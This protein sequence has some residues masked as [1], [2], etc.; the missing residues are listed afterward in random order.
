[1]L[2][3]MHV[4]SH[5]LPLGIAPVAVV[6]LPKLLLALP[7]QLLLPLL[8]LSLS[9]PL[10]LLNC[11]KPTTSASNS[12]TAYFNTLSHSLDD[13]TELVVADSGKCSG[14]EETHASPPSRALPPLHASPSS[15]A[16]APLHASPSSRA[17]APLHAS[18]SSRAL[19]PLHASPSSRALPPLHASPSSRALPPLHASPLSRALP[20]LHA[21]PSS[22][23]LLPP[24][25]E[26][27]TATWCT[28]EHVHVHAHGDS[29]AA[30]AS[31]ATNTMPFRRL[32]RFNRRVPGVHFNRHIDKN[33]H[34]SINKITTS[35]H[36]H[37]CPI[38][39]MRYDR[40]IHGKFGFVVFL[41]IPPPISL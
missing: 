35:Y 15:R 40:E 12:H 18:P 36:P 29:R 14:S 21:S 13:S 31:L 5:P 37:A 2:V 33:T 16:L 34:H 28:T 26:G 17:L 1:M 11:P 8:L 38:D 9:F 6:E 10:L 39:T 25:I 32:D 30:A 19:A 24:L 22:R 20:P 7:P 23:A 41:L 3:P 27:P 4:Q